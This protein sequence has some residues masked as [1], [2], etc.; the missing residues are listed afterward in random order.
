MIEAM[1]NEANNRRARR[2]GLVSLQVLIVRDGHPAAIP[3][4]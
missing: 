1:V 4:F 2:P 3:V